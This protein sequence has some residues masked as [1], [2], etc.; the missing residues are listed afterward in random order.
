[1]RKN[2]LEENYLSSLKFILETVDTY[3]IDLFLEQL[4]LD[5]EYINCVENKRI[6]FSTEKSEKFNP[7]LYFVKREYLNEYIRRFKSNDIDFVNNTFSYVDFINILSIEKENFL[8]LKKE[9]D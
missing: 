7:D 8:K 5:S 6:K 2:N 1:M 9:D 3:N 4:I